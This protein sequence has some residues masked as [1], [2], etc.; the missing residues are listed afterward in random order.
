ME[1]EERAEPYRLFSM[2][3]LMEIEDDPNR[4][5]V[6]NMIP[7]PGKILIYGKGGDYKTTMM[8]DLALAVASGGQLMQQ[9]PVQKQ[10]PVI[11]LSA[12]GSILTMKD[13]IFSHLRPRNINPTEIPFFF[14][15][16]EFQ[17]DTEPG[18]Q[19]LE[20]MI[21]QLKPIFVLIDPFVSFF[22]GD[23]NSVKDVRKFLR[24]LNR[25][26]RKCEKRKH[27]VSI[28]IIHHSGKSGDMRGSSA[29]HGWADSVLKS[30]VARDVKLPG[31]PDGSSVHVVSVDC[32]KQRDGRDGRVFTAVPFIDNELKMTTFG[33]YH[34]VEAKNVVDVF[35]R[36]NVLKTLR[37][38]PDPLTKTQLKDLLACS[39]E[40]VSEAL[41][42]LK[43][44]HLVQESSVRRSTSEDGSRGRN[45]DAWAAS[46]SS[47]LDDVQ[48]IIDA[49]K[50][51]AAEGSIGLD[52]RDASSICIPRVQARPRV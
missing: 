22:D 50:K 34:D 48:A 47:V 17:I 41:F 4:W 29:L 26:M 3:D 27:P 30:D 33:I 32:K 10:G 7:Y 46:K 52:D 16:D 14:G 42:I 24:P 9:F 49:A 2:T 25:I 44:A 39:A 31:L 13:R 19:L 18:A 8:L 28:A 35:F 5:I 21:M 12:E 1:Q 20:N 11:V 45:V 37:A 51:K 15:K 6:H 43:T 23:E 40:K 36:L 38:A